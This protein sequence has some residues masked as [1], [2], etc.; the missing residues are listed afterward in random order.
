MRSLNQLLWLQR[1][2]VRMRRLYYVNVWG[3]DIH[4]TAVFSN[5]ARFDKTNPKGIH[6]GAETY[7]AFQAA[8]LT[9]DMSRGLHLDTYIGKRCFIGARAI[10]LP[11]LQIG[12]EAIVG[13]GA[14]VTKNVQPRTVVAGNPAVVI[15]ENITVE[16]FGRFTRS[17][18][19]DALIS[20]EFVS[21]GHQ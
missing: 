10:I 20:S 18:V 15:K 8:V 1:F 9:H 11:G 14:V 12:D 16:K 17:N 21:C 3:M 6:I 13:A 19:S 5:S 4:P 2:S 7:V